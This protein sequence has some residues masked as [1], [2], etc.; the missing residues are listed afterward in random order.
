MRK[1]EA[2]SGLHMCNQTLQLFTLRKWWWRQNALRVE[3]FSLLVSKAHPSETVQSPV[4]SWWFQHKWPS[5]K[6]N[7]GSGYHRGPHVGGV[8][9]SKASGTLTA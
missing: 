7:V 4:K 2:I 6:S 9:Y 3:F 1:G 8:I 5:L